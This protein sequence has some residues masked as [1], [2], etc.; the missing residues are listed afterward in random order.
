MKGITMTYRENPLLDEMLGAPVTKERCDSKMQIRCTA[1]ELKMYRE[2][3]DA[4]VDLPFM[5]RE[6]VNKLHEKVFPDADL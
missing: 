5:V 3:M 4:D 2:L 1:D 6:F